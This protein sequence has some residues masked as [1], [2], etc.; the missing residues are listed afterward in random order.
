[1]MCKKIRL[2]IAF[3]FLIGITLGIIM[4]NNAKIEDESTMEFLMQCERDGYKKTD[5]VLMLNRNF[6]D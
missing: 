1:M 4:E 2:F 6:E 5:C 3:L